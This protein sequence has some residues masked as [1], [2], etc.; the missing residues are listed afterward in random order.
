MSNISRNT[1][2]QASAKFRCS[3]QAEVEQGAMM[4]RLRPD[5]CGQCDRGQRQR[6]DR[7]LRRGTRGGQGVQSGDQRHHEHGEQAESQPVHRLGLSCSGPGIEP[8]RQRRRHHRHNVQPEHC[9]PSRIVRQGAAH[10]RPDAEAQHQESGPG[11]DGPRAL[12]FGGGFGH[13]RQRAGN[14]EGRAEP[15][16]RACADDHGAVGSERDHHRGQ[17]EQRDP[18]G[19]G[20]SRP[21]LVRRLAAQNDE[22]GGGQQIGVHRPFHRGGTEREASRHLRQRG[23]DGR[24][25]LADRQHR[26]A[27]GDQHQGGITRHWSSEGSWVIQRIWIIQRH[28]S[29]EQSQRGHRPLHA[30]S[31][32]FHFLY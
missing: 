27:T 24:A 5:Q 26:Q 28:V 19:G 13:C 20:P 17:S 8:Q 31:Q 14:G 7:G 32:T 30:K 2:A 15:L 18:A 3:E 16:Q 11:A 21:E 12:R 10:E 22:D 1:S 23:H 9:S 29:S 4:T 25:V 6:N